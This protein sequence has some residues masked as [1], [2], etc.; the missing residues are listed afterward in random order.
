MAEIAVFQDQQSSGVAG[1][2]ITATITKQPFNTNGGN[3]VTGL[4]RSGNDFT[5]T[6]SGT[7]VINLFDAVVQTNITFSPRYFVETSANVILDDTRGSQTNGTLSDYTSIKE[8]LTFTISAP[9]TFS[10][11]S[12]SIAPCTRP[13][14]SDGVECY[15]KLIIQKL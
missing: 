10:V 3:T 15:Q 14:F 7:Y 5:A 8:V 1:T 9:T 12:E 4:T 13:A 6:E 2:T 11:Y